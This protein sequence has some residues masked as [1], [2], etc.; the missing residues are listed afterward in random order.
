MA[1]LP[2][3][4]TSTPHAAAVTA[5]RN[6]N[7]EFSDAF[8]PNAAGHS[9]LNAAAGDYDKAQL[10]APYQ[11]QAK[12]TARISPPMRQSLRSWPL[13]QRSRNCQFLFIILTRLPGAD[14]VQSRYQPACRWLPHT[15]AGVLSQPLGT[16]RMAAV[17]EPAHH[18]VH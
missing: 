1:M 9:P 10:S 18:A 12:T 13:R 14:H 8:S 7:V 16:R 3:Q 15:R 5:F 6:L 4:Q 17:P 2:H 11:S